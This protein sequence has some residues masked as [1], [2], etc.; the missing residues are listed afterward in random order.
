M[1]TFM[2]RLAES[3]RRFLRSSGLAGALL[4]SPRSVFSS[5]TDSAPDYTLH[6]RNSAIEIAPKRIIPATTY[7]GQFPG[8]LLRLKASRQVTVDLYNDTD[9]LEQLH[10]HGQ[11][12]STDVDGAAEDGT[13]YIPAHGKRRT[14]FTP[15]PAGLRFYHTHNRAG[16]NLSDGQYSGQVGPV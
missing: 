4:L 1:M 12:V 8:P 10:R 15:N 2:E 3:R 7:N 14:A 5:Q 16:P 11:K 13:P 9:T 6:I